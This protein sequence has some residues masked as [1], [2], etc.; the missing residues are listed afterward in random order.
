MGSIFNYDNKFFQ[1]MGKA[2]DCFY[3]SILWL[4]FCIPIVTIG[5]STT[6]LYETTHKVLR[7]SRG[8]VWRTFWNSFKS[9][10]RQTTKISVI[11]LVLFGVLFFDAQVMKGYLEQGSNL[12][13]LYYFFYIMMLFEYI[14]ALYTFSYSARFE[15]GMKDT[16]KN[17]AI[18]AV[19]NLPW[20]FLL[21][22]LFIVTLILIMI[23]PVFLF[24]L[25]AGLMTVYELILER[26]FRKIM[27]PEDLKKEQEEDWSNY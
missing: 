13:A 23:L 10:F 3:I 24:L 20:S 18:L 12:G 6:A 8:Y 9:N 14:W 25:P 7:R 4:I 17:G 5:A 11:M 22:L 15:M 26:I 27:L 1:F 16:M 21:L 19:V 2:V